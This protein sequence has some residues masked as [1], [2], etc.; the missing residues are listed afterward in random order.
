MRRKRSSKSVSERGAFDRSHN[1]DRSFA[2]APESDIENFGDTGKRGFAEVWDGVGADPAADDGAVQQFSSDED[3]DKGRDLD[4]R[5]KRGVLFLA[6][7]VLIGAGVGVAAQ[8]GWLATGTS[9][10]ADG[11]LA[12][13]PLLSPGQ[14]RIY[15]AEPTQVDLSLSSSST[16]LFLTTET[17]VPTP[18][19][20]AAP[21]LPASIGAGPVLWAGR[22]HVAVF[23]DG[24]GSREE[25]CVVVSLVAE[26]LVPIDIGTNGNCASPLD[27]TGDRLSC[28]GDDLILVEVWTDDPS[29]PGTPPP[30]VAIRYRVEAANSQGV[31]SRRGSFDVSGAD[32]TLVSDAVAMGGAPDDVVSI[33]SAD[34]VQRGTCTL[35]DRSQVE[36]RLLP[37]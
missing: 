11:T 27:T 14:V 23:G 34:G 3:D 21:A 10:E 16:E 37:S 31:L 8:Q 5:S 9:Q 15:E 30:T 29:S 35:L 19:N 26:Q 4:A 18:T 6:L 22:M 25:S 24:I 28:L 7:I 33:V 17:A 1:D 32:A 2:D 13:S 20:V 12:E 36:V